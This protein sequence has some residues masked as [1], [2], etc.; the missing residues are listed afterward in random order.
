[1]SFMKYPMR[2]W[3]RRLRMVIGRTFAY[4]M[5]ELISTLHQLGIE[6]KQAQVYLACLELGS[7]TVH[8]LAEKSGVKAHEYL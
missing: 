6:E 8:E 1:M 7:A 3:R 4:F 2:D 5:N